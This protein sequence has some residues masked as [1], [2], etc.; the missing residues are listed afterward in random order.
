MKKILQVKDVE[1]SV[2]QALINNPDMPY[3]EKLELF[4]LLKTKKE[5]YHFNKLYYFEPF[6]YQEK[7]FES[8]SKNYRSRF[9]CAANRIGK[10]YGASFECAVHLTGRYPSWWKGKVFTKPVKLW[11]VGINTKSVRDSLQEILLGTN[12]AK[13]VND[14]GTGMIPRKDIKLDTLQKEGATAE[15]VLVQHY[16]Q[17]GKP[18]GLSELTFKSTQMGHHALMGA[19]VDFILLDEEDKLQSMPIYTQCLTR[20][21]TTKGQVVIS[22]TPENGMTELVTKFKNEATKDMYYQQASA[23]EC[24]LYTKEEI[25]RD[26]LNYPTYEHGY[27]FYGD[28]S[29]ASGLIYQVNL[30]EI[31]YDDDD[32]K[33]ADSWKRIG[34]MDLGWDHPTTCVWSAYDANNDIIYVYGEYGQKEQ[35]PAVHA[36][37]VKM[38]GDWI[39]IVLPHDAENTNKNDG[40]AAKDIYKKV[41]PQVENELFYNFHT[42]DGHVNRSVKFGIDEIRERMK[43]GRIKISNT[44]LNLLSELRNYRMENNKIVK[45]KDDYCDAMRYSVMSVINRGVANNGRSNKWADIKETSAWNTNTKDW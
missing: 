38:R 29:I 18:D 41:L 35:I 25:E 42:S 19:T 1:D 23:F 40:I 34:A 2:R 20:T 27:R 11:A 14:I 10:S 26:M 44:C 12:N 33:I 9:L 43:T 17:F 15:T 45:E 4:Q 36:H 37:A 16:N 24:A 5:H 32:I 31:T 13:N 7:F 6:E 8:G 3:E 22:A 28:P 21:K 30:D 39:P